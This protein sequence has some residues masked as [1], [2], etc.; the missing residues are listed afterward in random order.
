MLLKNGNLI[1]GNGECLE[2]TDLRI[3]S[4]VISK[5]AV[6]LKPHLK[7]PV[8]DLSNC[9]VLPGLIDAH[10]HIVMSGEM[11][12]SNLP[13]KSTA[14]ITINAI[15][16]ASKLLYAGF[17]TVRDVG[18]IG[19]ID[20][21][22]RNAIA[23]GKIEGPRM[24]V[25]GKCI[26]MTGGHGLFLGAREADGPDEC[27]KAA[28]E[29]LFHSADQLKMMATGGAL[30]ESGEPGCSQLD[31]EEMAV[32]VKE[33]HNAGKKAAAHCHGLDGI[34]NAVEAGVDSVEH[35][36]YADDAILEEMARRGTYLCI[37]MRATSLLLDQVP[38]P[39]Y[40][41]DRARQLM[42]LQLRNCR[43][44]H[45]MGVRQAFGTD[46]GTPANYHGDNAKEFSFFVDCGF[47]PME[48]IQV[49]TSS[50]AE[51]LGLGDRI[52]TLEPNKA[53]DLFVVKG[54]PIE[55]IEVLTRPKE[56]ILLLLKEGKVVLD[57]I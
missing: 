11:D 52:G 38:V 30:T 44:A 25:S 3:E 55:E 29:Q 41:A 18:A 39:A 22:I 15:N 48:A 36:T 12:S 46:A 17:T 10:V 34:R 31:K 54:N 40:M 8:I 32:I 51:L 47:S 26:I 21:A 57:H 56:E 27:R 23:Q 13:S 14:E 7:E 53:A 9:W 35:G 33:A 19:Y 4:G 45:E 16:N 2:G 50:S 5:R 28:R 1:I 42:N 24:M 6:N 43:R 20:V 37:C 49:A